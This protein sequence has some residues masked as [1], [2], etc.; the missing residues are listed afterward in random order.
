MLEQMF[1]AIC[2]N[3]L[4]F[5]CSLTFLFNFRKY[6]KTSMEERIINIPCEILL[7]PNS[8]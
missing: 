4:Y 6:I 3:T 2:A 1:V 7:Y 8:R 5:K